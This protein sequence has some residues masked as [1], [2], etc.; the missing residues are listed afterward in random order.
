MFK[1]GDLIEVDPLSLNNFDQ[2]IKEI[3]EIIGP[4]PWEV[5]DIK[6]VVGF[7]LIKIKGFV[8]MWPRWLLVER[9]Q[10]FVL[11]EKAE[12]DNWKNGL[13]LL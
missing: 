6:K 4:P 7:D 9:F 12:V 3:K 8:T 13:D 11:A 1:I 5:E 10:L 2:R